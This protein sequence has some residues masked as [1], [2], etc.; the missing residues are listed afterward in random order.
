MSMFKVDTSANSLVREGGAFVRTSGVDE[1]RQDHQVSVQILRGE[2]AFD[3]LLGFDWLGSLGKVPLSILGS[4]LRAYLNK[5]PGVVEVVSLEVEDLGDRRVRV[6]Y[7][8]R[9]SVDALRRAVLVEDAIT[10]QG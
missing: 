4:R 3:L 8:A 2:Y 1:I 5:R 7:T 6:P 10:V 9:V